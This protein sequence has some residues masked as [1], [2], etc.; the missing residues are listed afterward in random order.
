MNQ[1]QGLRCHDC[2]VLPGKAHQQG[3]DQEVC[4]YCGLQAI[5]CGCASKERGS[6]PGLPWTGVH[7]GVAECQELGL[8]AKIVPG[9]PGWT[10]CEP[11]DPEGSPDLNRLYTEAKWD[12]S[13]RRWVRQ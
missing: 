12:R 6:L 1:T 11:S 3:C 2:G 10:R 5:G 8:F 7:S 4:A 13:Q 9:K